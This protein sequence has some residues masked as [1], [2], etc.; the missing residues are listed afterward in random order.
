MK[1][2]VSLFVR[3]VIGFVLVVYVCYAANLFSDDGWIALFSTLASANTGWL[4]LA[5]LYIP[6]IDFISTI[7]WHYLARKLNFRV[8]F[9]RLFVFYIVGRFFN[10]VLPSSIGGDIV[11]VH[12]LA[13]ENKRYAQAAAVVFVERLTGV[14]TLVTFAILAAFI[15]LEKFNIQWLNI[16][17]LVA[18][19][20][21]VL[22]VWLIIDDRLFY[23][24]EK[25]FKGRNR[26]IDKI[27][28]K[29]A[30]FKEAATQYRNDTK[31]I[32]LAFVYSLVFYFFAIFNFWVTAMVFQNDVSL[33]SM[34]IAVPIIMFIM[35]IPLS[36]GGIGI[37]EFAY[38]FVLSL[39]GFAPEIALSIALLMRL[40]TL[41]AA[42]IGACIYP[43]VSSWGVNF[44]E[45][46]SDTLT[47]D[48]VKSKM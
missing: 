7:K 37:M 31:S 20:G 26:I 15:A 36:V 39:F 5:F 2:V 47:E 3:L 9:F 1:K 27:L 8:S 13:R 12:L 24:V 4:L 16:A 22:L 46:N 10:L 32:I 17:F 45:I 28:L 44:D 33:T 6:F 30:K 11:R 23:F 29:T 38:T 21:V 48:K 25:L 43:V 40:K 19:I 18:I 42:A 14:I 41:I 35:N 34:F